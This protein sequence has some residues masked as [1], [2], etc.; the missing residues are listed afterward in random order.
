MIMP[1]SETKHFA[2]TRELLL[3]PVVET[4]APLG[5]ASFGRWNQTGT[6]GIVSKAQRGASSAEIDALVTEQWA[7]KSSVFLKN[8]AAPLRR[9]GKDIDHE[10]QRMQFQRGNLIDQAI[11]CHCD[12][13]YAASVLLT[14][15][16]IDGLTR[17][18]TGA[19][20]FSNSTNDEYLDDSTLAG[21]ATN[22]PTV[23]KA[24]REAVNET[25]FHGKLSRH[26]A[27][28]GR[29][30]SFG[31]EITSTKALVLLG[32]L[33]EYLEDRASKA[34]LKF[35]RKRDDE[36]K[37]L[38][39]TDETGRLRDERHL[40]QLYFFALDLDDHIRS[41]MVAVLADPA[42]W[43][44][45]AH[46][47]LE[48]KR[49]NRGAFVWGGADSSSY[50]WAY[51]APGGHYLGAGGRRVGT[52]FPIEW[53]QWRWDSAE[54]PEASPWVQSE[55]F[56]YEGQPVTPNWTIADFPVT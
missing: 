20:F 9:Y 1:Q 18:I 4:L 33:V 25:G 17:D 13:Y 27:A 29:D 8:I 51:R 2:L 38:S 45:K 36:A 26:G 19:T 3:G 56:E 6:H 54:P 42:A 11:R 35:R 7:T 47:L 31:T 15:A 41:H 49:L 40:D 43:L 37:K 50:W 44:Q 30:L 39:G 24:F 12:G 46:E 55:W 10:F 48:Q 34:A 21:I 16:Q 22:L 52:G 14:Y 23:R 28:H 53:R 32:A 5:W